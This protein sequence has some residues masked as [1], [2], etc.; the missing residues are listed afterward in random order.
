MMARNLVVQ[1][2]QLDP[3]SAEAHKYLA[4]RQLWQVENE[5]RERASSASLVR[6]GH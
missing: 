3:E 4:Y 5:D 6:P 2:R 1:G